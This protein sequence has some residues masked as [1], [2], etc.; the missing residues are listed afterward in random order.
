MQHYCS[1]LTV[2]L[3]LFYVIKLFSPFF[4]FFSCFLFQ[5]HNNKASLSPCVA[6]FFLNCDLV[7]FPILKPVHW[8]KQSAFILIN[9]V[10]WPQLYLGPLSLSWHSILP[11]FFLI[12][13]PVFKRFCLFFFYWFS[14]TNVTLVLFLFPL[15]KPV[16][17]WFIV[18]FFFFKS[19]PHF[20]QMF[21]NNL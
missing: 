1:Y 12:L 13:L 2:N 11:I 14:L 10:Y 6:F 5:P 17:F 21:I 7:A 20:V 15:L 18:S 19:L 4:F 16:L 3:C 8:L 9:I